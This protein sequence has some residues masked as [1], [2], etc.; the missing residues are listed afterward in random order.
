MKVPLADQAVIA[1][2][3]LCNYY[4]GNKD[5]HTSRAAAYC[6]WGCWK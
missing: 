5:N 2:D 1:Q 6:V 4:L 3:K